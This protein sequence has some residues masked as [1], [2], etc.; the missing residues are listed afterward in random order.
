MGMPTKQDAFTPTDRS[1]TTSAT[2]STASNA[3]ASNSSRRGYSIQNLSDSATIW[4]NHSG[5]AAANSGRKLLPNSYWETPLGMSPKGAISVF[6][7][8]ASVPIFAEEW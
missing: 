2:P 4:V 8:S 1:G 6:S 5:T 7:T 3:I